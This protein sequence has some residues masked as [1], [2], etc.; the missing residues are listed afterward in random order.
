MTNPKKKKSTEL[1]R[2]W[3]CGTPMI[4]GA[5]FDYDDYCMEGVGIVSTFSCPTCPTTAEVYYT[6]KEAYEEETNS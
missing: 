6:I 5:D 3:H 1:M 2:C 4:W